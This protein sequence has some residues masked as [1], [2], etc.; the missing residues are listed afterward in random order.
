M[1]DGILHNIWQRG[2]TYAKTNYPETIIS[3]LTKK[4]YGY[5][6]E[7]SDD[8]DLRFDQQGN[9]IEEVD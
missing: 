9:F 3:K 1:Q 2:R 4:T 6:I 5:K 7:L 8:V